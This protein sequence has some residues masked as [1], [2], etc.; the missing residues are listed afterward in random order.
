MG[1]WDGYQ[2]SGGGA[3]GYMKKTMPVPQEKKKGNFLTNHLDTAGGI[4]GG[5]AGA[6][7]GTAIM[8]GVGTIIGGLIG[9]T[10]GGAGGKAGS[11]ALQGEKLN[12]GEILKAGAV[13][14]AGELV[15]GGIGT[16]AAKVL[17]KLASKGAAPVADFLTN[18]TTKNITKKIAPNLPV[19]SLKTGRDI[20]SLYEKSGLAANVGLYSN[21]AREKAAKLVTGSNGVV[22]GIKQQVLAQSGHVPILDSLGDTV[23]KALNENGVAGMAEKKALRNAVRAQVEKAAGPGGAIGDMAVTADKAFKAQQAL[24]GLSAAARAANKPEIAKAYQAV[25]KSVGE[26][27]DTHAGANA[28]VAG[29]KLSADQAKHIATL[30]TKQLGKAKGNRLAQYV[31]D[32]VNDAKSIPEL[33]KIESN[34]IPG[35]QA[36]TARTA[37]G[38]QKG[39]GDVIETG[40]EALASPYGKFQLGKMIGQGV[41]SMT[42]PVFGEAARVAGKVEPAIPKVLQRVAGQ[43]GAGRVAAGPATAALAEPEMPAQ[44]ESEV[45]GPNGYGSQASSIFDDTSDSSTERSPYG[46]ENLMSDIQRDPKNASTYISLYKTLNTENSNKVSATQ[47]KA[48]TGAKN[49]KSTLGQ[50]ESSFSTAGGG[51][52]KL[53]GLFANIGGKLGLNSDVDTYNQ[54]ATSL[55]AS[56][57]KALGNT[58]TVT[59]KD[60]Q[61]IASL[62]PKTTDS[63]I[64]AESKVAQLESL[65]QQAEENITAPQGSG[66]DYADNTELLKMLGVQ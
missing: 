30:A 40:T 15:G 12:A 21:A 29:F 42:T 64:T 36:A 39:T 26:Q 53:G 31:I 37:K 7:A 59:D 58:G 45:Q 19:S 35:A 66:N 6:A 20:G 28:A 17:P 41:N 47:Q 22:N 60:Q 50:I 44:D 56:L 51:R 65:L 8:P 49:A 52:G 62:I 43:A 25:A 3:A 11:E 16:V 18:K 9:A 63:K 46:Q 48:I 5:L 2:E 23:M 32:G 54:T 33:R 27:I 13:N 55:A 24:E 4:G 57:Y 34:F 1:F 61:F 10:I 38:L 14:G